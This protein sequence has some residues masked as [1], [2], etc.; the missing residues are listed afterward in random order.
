MAMITRWRWWWLGCW[1]SCSLRAGLGPGTGLRFC[2]WLS[3]TQIA[4]SCLWEPKIWSPGIPGGIFGRTAQLSSLFCGWGGFGVGPL[5]FVGYRE[6][7]LGAWVL[8]PWSLLGLLELICHS[9]LKNWKTILIFCLLK[10]GQFA[11]KLL[12]NSSAI[13]IHIVCWNGDNLLMNCCK[14]ILLPLFCLQNWRQFANKLLQDNS[15]LKQSPEVE[16]ICL[17]R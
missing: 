4:E 2:L 17:K 6:V 5:A 15:D 9:L 14:T 12:Q 16:I 13:T 8:A 1:C 11:Y 3:F 10:W 7:P